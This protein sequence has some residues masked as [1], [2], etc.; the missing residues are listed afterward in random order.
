LAANLPFNVG[1]PILTN[2]LEC[3]R[4][5]VSMTVTIQKEL[6]DRIT[7]SP[8]TKD[9]GSLSIWIQSQCRAEIVRL[10]PPTVFWP[11]PK[12]TSAILHIV[13]DDERRA[14][15]G[16]PVFFH[17]F[18]RALLLHRRKFLRGVL[19]AGYKESLGKPG[20]DALLAE[21]ELSPDCRAEQLDVPTMLRLSDAV[22][23]RLEQAEPPPKRPR[24]R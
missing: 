19:I 24:A 2:L 23:R 6:A 10:L 5:P 4:P 20:V 8:G 21:L 11:R 14:A 12:V 18:I 16:N 1:T 9:Y 7:A 13:R 3:D 15:I 22:E 17:R